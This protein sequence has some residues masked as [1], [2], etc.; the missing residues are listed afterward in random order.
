[1]D[2]K[3]FTLHFFTVLLLAIPKFFMSVS[4][5]FHKNPQGFCPLI[6]SE[7]MDEIVYAPVCGVGVFLVLVHTGVATVTI[8]D[9]VSNL[10]LSEAFVYSVVDLRCFKRNIGVAPLADTFVIFVCLD[11]HGFPVF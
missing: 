9:K 5:I 2:C 7:F 8:Q 4:E 1:M 3:A 11:S 10:L 6:R